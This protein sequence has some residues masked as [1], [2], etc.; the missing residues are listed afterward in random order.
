[1]TV[2]NYEPTFSSNFCKNLENLTEKLI[3]VV[4]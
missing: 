4:N 3:K 1:M 2:F